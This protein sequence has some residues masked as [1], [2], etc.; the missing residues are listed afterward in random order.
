MS[1]NELLRVYQE[2]I[3]LSTETSDYKRISGVIDD[4]YLRDMLELIRSAPSEHALAAALQGIAERLQGDI[5]FEAIEIGSSIRN[6]I[7]RAQTLLAFLTVAENKDLL[8][9][10]I[11]LAA[12][13]TFQSSLTGDPGTLLYIIKQNPDLF[14]RRIFTKDTLF[15]FASS[16]YHI[17]YQWQWQ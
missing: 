2:I 6:T 7:L 1:G 10:A 15:S 9:P 3:K 16:I 12:L 5:L 8:L 17:C 4:I 11:R 14:S 13:E